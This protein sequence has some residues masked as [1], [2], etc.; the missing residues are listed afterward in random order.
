MNK[1]AL[2]GIV[3]A[4]VAVIVVAAAVVTVMNQ[5]PE[6]VH[7]KEPHVEYY[8]NGGVLST[9]EAWI[10]STMSTVFDNMFTRDGYTFTE[11]NTSADG[12]GD[13]YRSGS[14]VE[15]GVKLYAQWTQHE[16]KVTFNLSVNGNTSYFDTVTFVSNGVSHPYTDA[17]YPVEGDYLVIT[18]TDDMT[19]EVSDKGFTA[20]MISDNNRYTY[21][22]NVYVYDLNG[23][24][25]SYTKS[26]DGKIG[27]VVIPVDA[28]C[29]ISVGV[30][31]TN[32]TTAVY[33]SNSASSDI[34]S[35]KTCQTDSDGYQY[36]STTHG[37]TFS[38]VGHVLK[39]W[40][41]AKDGS[42]TSYSTT[43]T[44]PYQDDSGTETTVY[45]QWEKVLA[46]SFD[47]P[48]G[49]DYASTNLTFKY[50]ADGTTTEFYKATYPKDLPIS[51][52]G[53]FTIEVTKGYSS[54]T[55]LTKVSD[56][57]FT[58][59]MSGKTYTVTVSFDKVTL[60]ST[61][62]S[63]GKITMSCTADTTLDSISGVVIKTTESS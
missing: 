62:M 1:S 19:A 26:I 31:R 59:V 6:R 17:W 39:S 51:S 57:T 37:F 33:N 9:G 28:G 16:D 30:Y 50:T 52:D 43:A 38:W 27:K 58:Y 7:T 11:W 47:N 53:E 14:T 4:A 5:E 41:T 23:N 2:I 18:P 42:G 40:N 35:E 3:V 60:N 61:V 10:D 22:A 36:I 13:S 20:S 21:T 32:T 46:Y 45:A 55:D 54:V 49:D 24:T 63:D 56:T 25:M 15:M 34:M 29:R 8:G 12:S 44:I 48:V